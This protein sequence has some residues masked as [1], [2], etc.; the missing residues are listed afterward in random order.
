MAPLTC[1]PVV[2]GRRDHTFCRICEAACGLQVQRNPQGEAIGLRPDRE[3]P[4]SRGFA[5]AKGTRFFEVADHP[6]RVLHPRVGG[7]RVAWTDAL[8]EVSD[9]LRTTVERH[10]PHA[11][12]VYFGNPMAFNA[13]GIAAIVHF[14]NV[15]GTRNVFF[16]GSQDCNNKFTASRIL[17]GSPFVHPIPDFEHADF[18]LVLGSN[19]YV[20]QSSFV[21]LE[22]GSAQAFGGIVRRGGDIVWVDPRRTESAKRWGRHL[23]IAPGTDVWLLLGLLKLVTDPD[24]GD[25]RRMDGPR[26]RVEGFA[27]LVK[28]ASRV[29]LDEVAARTRIDRPA[30]ESL[31][32]DLSNARRAALHMSVGV[33]M[34]GFGTLSYVLLQALSYATGNLD[35][36]GGSLFA[37]AADPIAWIARRAGLTAEAYSRVGNFRSTV[38]SLP[39]GLLADEILTDGPERI[40]SL[41]VVGG[42]PL[43]SVP[44]GARLQHALQSLEHLACVDMFESRTATHAHAFLPATSWLERW[45]IGLPSIPFQRS[46]LMQISGPVIPPRGEAR[47]DAQIIAEL[48]RGMKLPGLVWRV[49]ASDLGRWLPQPRYGIR[50]L[51]PRPGRY[52]RKHRVRFWSSE[53]ATEVDRV[54]AEDQPPAGALRLIGRRRRLGHNSWMHGGV[55]DGSPEA[56]AWMH[57]DDL[58]ERG[59]AEGET[60]RL[61][62][63][64]GDV[65]LPVRASTDVM[66]GTVVVPHGLHGSSINDIVPSGAAHIE[67]ISGQHVMTGIDVRVEAV[68]R[69]SAAR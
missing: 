32:R 41:L 15:L 59:L 34:G 42:D 22:G 26:D 18:A 6:T 54:R 37:A 58:H 55:R 50:G 66:R 57:P 53:I 17:H 23:P 38:R 45:D 28:A 8:T 21:H 24:R 2:V 12:G 35:R 14:V 44:G 51:R 56:F 29:D 11:V 40:R 7:Q 68:A 10:G 1:Y 16:A 39:A 47:H 61:Q 30:I 69:V 33:N 67:R 49:L 19:P 25:G 36:E 46:D 52:L 62:T 65:Q 48:A 63:E 5:C 43:R 4:T 31:A 27:E 64:A 60:L 3:H 20:S 9:A 13:L